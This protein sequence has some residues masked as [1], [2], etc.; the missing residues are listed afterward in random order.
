MTPAGGVLSAA[1]EEVQYGRGIDNDGSAHQRAAHRGI[2]EN[3]TGERQEIGANGRKCLALEISRDDKKP[4]RFL[5]YEVF[6]DAE[7]HAAHLKLPRTLK[8]IE[9]VE[10]WSTRK[11]T[12]VGPIPRLTAPNK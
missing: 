11:P 2:H 5:I 10:R 9:A 3:G 7:A 1:Q 12:G 6:I 8:M 4:G